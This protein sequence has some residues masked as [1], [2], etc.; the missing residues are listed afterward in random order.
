MANCLKVCVKGAMPFNI[1]QIDDL[2]NESAVHV[3]RRFLAQTVLPGYGFKFRFTG[4]DF[5][6][7]SRYGGETTFHPFMLSGTEAIWEDNFI[8]SMRAFKEAG[9]IIESA[10]VEDIEYP[11]PEHSILQKINSAL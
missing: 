11:V 9:A 2:A 3:V 4:S 6:K 5:Y 7:P 8:N 10:T 1:L